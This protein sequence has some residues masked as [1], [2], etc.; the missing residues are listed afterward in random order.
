[1][2]HLRPTGRSK[3]R[4]SLSCLSSF[5]GPPQTAS[6]ELTALSSVLIAV[7]RED[8]GELEAQVRGSRHAWDI[9]LISADALIKLVQIKENAEGAETGLKIRSLL[10]PM[11]Y[12]RLDK[13]I[14][15]MFTAAKE[16]E[17]AV[18]LP[19]EAE[20]SSAL[21]VRPVST[22]KR[23]L[24]LLI[25]LSRNTARSPGSFLLGATRLCFV[26]SGDSNRP[27]LAAGDAGLLDAVEGGDIYDLI[28]IRPVTPRPL[29][30]RPYRSLP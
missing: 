16:V 25:L 1:M 8:T 11:E 15:V 12:T 2:S 10:A 19:E 22:P 30:D 23:T 7:G 20:E 3:G 18:S 28:P 13:M 6:G 14:D 5:R 17:A 4:L 24:P 9:R 29:S 21:T 27:S 26:M